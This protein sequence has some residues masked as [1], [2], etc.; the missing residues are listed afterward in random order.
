MNLLIILIILHLDVL[1]EM[2]SVCELLVFRT[3][4]C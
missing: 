3:E 1:V 4:A 2:A